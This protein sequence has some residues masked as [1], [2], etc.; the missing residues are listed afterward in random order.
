MGEELLGAGIPLFPE[1][2]GAA[3]VVFPEAGLRFVNAE[4]DGLARGEVEVGG[5]EALFVESVSG[6]VHDAEERGGKVVIFVTGGEADV[7]RA[8]GS[9]EGVG[10]GVDAALGEVEAEGFGDFAVEGLL[11]LDRGGAVEEVGGNG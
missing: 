7:G 2:A 4:G 1:R 5:G 9:A 10:G 8:E 3:D 6:F 11:G